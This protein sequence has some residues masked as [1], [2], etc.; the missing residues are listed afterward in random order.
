MSENLWI[1][2]TFSRSIET[3]EKLKLWLF[4]VSGGIEKKHWAKIG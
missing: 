4:E 2:L 1:F 3:S